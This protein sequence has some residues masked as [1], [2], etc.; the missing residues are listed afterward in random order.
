M[1][2]RTFQGLDPKYS[3]AS[4]TRISRGLVGAFF[5]LSAPWDFGRSRSLLSI[6]RQVGGGRKQD[7]HRHF[8]YGSQVA[9]HWLASPKNQQQSQE[10][11]HPG[12]QHQVRGMGRHCPPGDKDYGQAL[13]TGESLSGEH[14]QIDAEIQHRPRMSGMIRLTN[15]LKLLRRLSSTT[16]RR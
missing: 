2:W 5:C 14:E 16:R 4:R 7:D 8:A 10:D 12:S 6:L 15:Q 1:S 11:T 3:A 9:A 13:S